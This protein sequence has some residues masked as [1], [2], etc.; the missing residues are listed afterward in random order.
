MEKDLIS[1]LIAFFP[2]LKDMEFHYSET[3]IRSR[4]RVIYGTREYHAVFSY[5]DHSL[6]IGDIKV[7][8]MFTQERLKSLKPFIKLKN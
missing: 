2:Y 1:A 7:T 5:E 4:V 6:I 3:S 8:H